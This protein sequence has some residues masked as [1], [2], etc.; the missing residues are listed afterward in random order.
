MTTTET[1][2][3]ITE[4]AAAIRA[5]TTTSVELVEQCY[6]TADAYDGEVGMFLARYTESALQAAAVADADLAAGKDV[7]PLHGIPL[8]IKDI[9]T[10][11]EGPTTGQ[12]VVHDR[13]AMSGDA[14]VVDRLRSA[15]G[16]VL[17][18]LTTMEFAIG[19]PDD[20]K[21]FPV[22]RN[23]WSLEH[24]AGG[25]SSGSGSAV[26]SGAVLGALGTDTG[27]SIRIPAA[28]CGISGLMPTFGRVPKSGCIPL[29]YS[30]DHIGPMAR[31]AADCALMLDVLAGYDASDLCAIDVPVDAYSGALTGDLTGVRIGADRLA[32]IGGEKEDPAVADAFAAALAALESRGATVVEVELPFYAEM[33][34]A[35]MVILVSEAFAYHRPDLQ[36]RWLDYGAA[37]RQILGTAIFYSAMDFVQA[38]RARTVGTRALS[39]LYADVDLIVTP[40][41]G[42]G[43]LSF[44]DLAGGLANIMAPIYTG[45]WDTTGNPVLSVPMGFTAAGLPLGLQVAGRPFEEGLV[46]R[47]GDA[48]Q[49]VT[50]HHLRV[51]AAPDAEEVAA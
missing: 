40:T 24:W 19:A 38:Q 51:P 49:Q 4:A 3:T 9:I 25:S 48:F 16:L 17:G 12:S 1:A 6:A 29:G 15:G 32:R 18:K 20:T 26:S 21:P 43:A 41:S 36:E 46:L 39:A 23:P 47:A 42:V 8:G 2:L 28:F 5:G 34:T 13:T 44:E 31:S 45:Y 22:P 11:R 30:L 35:D 37:T 14:V 33:S 10:T 50:D 27:G 7:G